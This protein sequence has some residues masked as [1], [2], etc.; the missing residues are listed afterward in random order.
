MQ[1][2]QK[3]INSIR[4]VLTHSDGLTPTPFK[5]YFE[6]CRKLG[7]ETE[8]ETIE[9]ILDVLFLGHVTVASFVTNCV[10]FL[11]LYPE[12]AERLR[13]EIERHMCTKN[14][15]RDR[16]QLD[17]ETIKNMTYLDCVCREVL[18][19]C[20]PVGAGFKKAIKSFELGVSFSVCK[21]K[22][23]KHVLNPVKSF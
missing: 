21:L 1:A 2:K 19:L 15:S 17:Y 6:L 13:E 7:T 11:G 9:G 18:R 12:V 8:V 5:G 14:T 22:I 23:I 4:E 3:L 20:P 10:M 16:K